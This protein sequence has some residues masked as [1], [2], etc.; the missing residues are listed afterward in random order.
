MKL[1]PFVFAVLFWSIQCIGQNFKFSFD[2]CDLKSTIGDGFTEGSP[3]CVCG[4]PEPAIYLD[5]INDGFT[6]PDTLISFLNKDFTLDFY[7]KDENTATGQVQIITVGS[8]CGLDS[9]LTLKRL[10]NTNEIIMEIFISNGEYFFV[11]SKWPTTQCWNRLTIVKLGLKYIL[12][13]NNEEVGK[14]ITTQNVSFAK[15]ASF[16]FSSGSCIPSESNR[17]KGRIDEINFY[18][19]ALTPRTLEQTHLYPETIITNDTTIYLGSSVDIHYGF[20]CANTYAWTPTTGLADATNTNVT[21]TPEVTTTYTIEAND[22]GCPIKDQITINV[23]DK[24]KVDCSK[25]LLPNAFTPNNDR[26]NDDFG[27]SNTFIVESIK[28]FD[29]LDRWGELLFQTLDSNAKWNGTYKGKDAE[30]G[31]Y[32]YKINYTCKGEEFAKAGNFVLIK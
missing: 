27:I 16:T 17:Y 20:E 30:P 26:L 12:Y 23:V 9:L 3:V 11:K 19:S 5:G 14:V 2:N 6:L 13:I 18:T 29:I 21:A 15:N 28:T 10:M 22:N 1:I 7:V 31:I 25:L 8:D 4:L 32:V 24:D